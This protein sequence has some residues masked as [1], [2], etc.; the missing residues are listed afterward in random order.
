MGATALHVQLTAL[1]IDPAQYRPLQACL[2]KLGVL[3]TAP[4][5]EAQPAWNAPP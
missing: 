1:G 5:Q 4:P 2:L 3:E